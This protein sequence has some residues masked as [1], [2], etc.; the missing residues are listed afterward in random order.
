MS[1]S[2]GALIGSILS[3]A[4]GVWVSVGSYTI[5]SQLNYL[6]TNTEKCDN[7]TAIHMY[8][9]HAPPGNLTNLQSATTDSS[10]P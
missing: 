4:F 8:D 2:Q 1:L 9:A 5:E 6:P 10:L 7:L 3:A